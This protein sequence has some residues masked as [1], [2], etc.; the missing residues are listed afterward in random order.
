MGVYAIYFYIFAVGNLK[1]IN[2]SLSK[3]QS[4]TVMGKCGI[5]D[6]VI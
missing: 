6:G 2:V 3:L 4:W 1:E 5:A